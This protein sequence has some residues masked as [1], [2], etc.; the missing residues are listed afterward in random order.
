MLLGTQDKHVRLPDEALSFQGNFWM[1]RY[2][3][4]LQCHGGFFYS[5][6]VFQVSLSL[7]LRNRLT[8]E[9]C[10]TGQHEWDLWPLQ[11]QESSLHSCKSLPANKALQ[12]CFCFVSKECSEL[13]FY[14]VDQIPFIPGPLSMWKNN[15]IHTTPLG[16]SDC[17]MQLHFKEQVSGTKGESMTNCKQC[18][19]HFC[20]MAFSTDWL[21]FSYFYLIYCVL[22]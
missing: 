7:F 14:T 8:V 16:Y 10:P 9:A 6:W 3:A 13:L 15:N 20:W 4:Y 19:S 17:A 21:F 1:G 11:W 12:L 5:H 22:M 18:K 2:R